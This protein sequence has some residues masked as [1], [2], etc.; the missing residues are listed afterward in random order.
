MARPRRAPVRID[1]TRPLELLHTHITASLCQTVFATVRRTERQRR[2][3]LELLIQFWLAVVLRA[4]R[5][6]SHALAETLPAWTD[7]LFPQVAASPEAF[8]QRCRTL[9][10]AFFREVFARFTAQLLAAAPARYRADLAAL[11]G[12][13]AALCVVDGS[14]L[15]AIAHRLKLLWAERAVILPGCLLAVYDVGRGL[16]RVLAFDPD[17]GAG[18]LPRAEAALRALPR[19]SLC[20]A[21]RLFCTAVWFRA[22]AAAGCWGVVR[23]NRSLGLTRLRRLG[24]TRLQGGRLEE[25]LVAAGARHPVTLRYIRWHRGRTVHELVTSVLDR[26]RLSAAEALALYPARWT[27]ER[28]Y[29]DL[30]EVLNLNRIYAAN[31]RAVAMQVYAAG[32][33]YNAL[34]V[35]QAEVAAAA[36]VA[37]EAISPAKFFPKVAAACHAYAL[38][39]YS[40]AETQ[41]ANPGRRL[42]RPDLTGHRFATVPLAAILVE[43]RKGPR[44]KRRFCAA[45]GRWKSL[46][47]VRGARH[48]LKN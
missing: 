7:P 2:W 45:R 26:E 8:F 29:F 35:A 9:R 19:E 40:F 25:W 15:A 48:L 31:P 36:Q 42:Q 38:V 12:R 37:P 17:A 32:C 21:D 44:R 10:P 4:P 14:S 34:R 3:T 11:Q 16:C 22:L 27:I 33:V 39:E 23:R 24:Q 6:L 46:A 20:V 28:M 47:H 5:A 41:A 30:K 43:R 13:F 18:E 1:L